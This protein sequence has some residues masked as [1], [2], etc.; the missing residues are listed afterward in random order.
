VKV[1]PAVLPLSFIFGFK[2]KSGHKGPEF[3][4]IV[5]SAGSGMG[6]EGDIGVSFSGYL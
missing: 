6:F 4:G 2:N 5:V 3:L 1:K